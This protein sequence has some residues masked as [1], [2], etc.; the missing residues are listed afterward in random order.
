MS[1]RK[2]KQTAGGDGDAGDSK[3]EKKGKQEDMVVAQIAW[4]R[5]DSLPRDAAMRTMI[6]S[7][8]KPLRVGDL[9]ACERGYRATESVLVTSVDPPT[10][11]SFGD[12][13][14]YMHVPRSLTQHIP[15]PLS[16]WGQALGRYEGISQ[17]VFDMTAH[18]AWLAETYTGGRKLHADCVVQWCTW[19]RGNIVIQSPPSDDIPGPERRQWVPLNRDTPDAYLSAPNTELKV[20]PVMAGKRATNASLLREFHYQLDEKKQ[21]SRLFVSGVPDPTNRADSYSGGSIVFQRM[22]DRPTGQTRTVVGWPST[23]PMLNIMPETERVVIATNPYQ[24]GT[25]EFRQKVVTQ[26]GPFGGLSVWVAP[27]STN[28]WMIDVSISF[29]KF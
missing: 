7:T 12:G 16:F 22:E 3:G 19:E 25:W 4:C 15:R 5:G 1:K 2:R 13:A 14:G 21:G 26:L 24:E 11:D 9:I 29:A 27:H 20:D 18:G 17:F 10:F 6:K 23:G 28:P 8:S